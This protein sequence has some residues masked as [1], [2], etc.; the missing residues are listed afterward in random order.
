MPFDGLLFFRHLGHWMA[1]KLF[2]LMC[3][4]GQSFRPHDKIHVCMAT[5]G[6]WK[7]LGP[8]HVLFQMGGFSIKGE[9]TLWGGQKCCHIVLFSKG[10]HVWTSIMVILEHIFLNFLHNM[11]Y[12]NK[13]NSIKRFFFFQLILCD[14]KIYLWQKTVC[15]YVFKMQIYSKNEWNDF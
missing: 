15:H 2:W 1:S 11:V 13:K 7:W 6:D 9:S 12:H 14:S 4:H 3:D 5:K 10:V 8:M